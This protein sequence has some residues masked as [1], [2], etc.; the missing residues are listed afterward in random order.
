MYLGRIVELGSTHDIFS[1]PQHPYTQ[2][3]LSAAPLPD[4]AIQR[5]RKRI[6]LRGEVPRPD[7]EYPGCP[8][9][10]RCPI[11]ESSCREQV[12]QLAGAARQVSCLK[13]SQDS[14]SGE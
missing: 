6:V 12:P 4:P 7:Q 14:L 10:D 2:A 1:S 5:G 8:F 3:L 9:A 11:V 13:V